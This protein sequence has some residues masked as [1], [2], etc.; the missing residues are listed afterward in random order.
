MLHG[1]QQP[2]VSG[3]ELATGLINL[4]EL[5]QGGE[6]LESVWIDLLPEGQ[7][8]PLARVLVSLRAMR[9]M[10]DVRAD[11]DFEEAELLAAPLVALSEPGELHPDLPEGLEPYCLMLMTADC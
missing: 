11:G 6:D 5:E 9:A 2:G 7:V 4:E 8:E 10:R 1:I 3:R